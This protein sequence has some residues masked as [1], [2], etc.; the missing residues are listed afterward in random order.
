[1]YNVKLTLNELLDIRL[2]LNKAIKEREEE[3]E[4]YTKE[5]AKC[6]DDDFKHIELYT[7]CRESCYSDIESYT[8]ILDKLYNA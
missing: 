2:L 5:I 8:T 4:T 3:I 6:K 7:R 1:M